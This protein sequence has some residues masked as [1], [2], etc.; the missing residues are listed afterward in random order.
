MKKSNLILFLITTLV[1]STYAQKDD[2]VV[3]MTVNGK[4]VSKAEFVRIY[5]KNNA[6]EQSFDQ[7]SLNEYLDLFINFKLKVA[8]AESLGLD[9]SKAFIDELAGYRKQLAKPYL[10]DKEVDHK[11]LLEAYDHLLW[12]VKASHILLK[13]DENASP[14][15]TLKVYNRIMDFRKKILD[16]ESFELVAKR[17]SE[18]PSA[19]S[20]GGSLGYFTGFQMVYPFERVAFSTPVGE[21]SMPVRTR[22]GYHLIKVFDKRPARGKVKVAHLMVAIPKTGGSEEASKA[23]AD[24]LLQL[25]KEGK[26]FAQ[27]AKENSD[28]HGSAAKGGELPMF[29]TGRMVPEF[30]AAAFKLESAGEISPLVK[31]SY[32][33]HIIK[34]LE[35]KGIEP[36]EDMKQE[37]K[38]RISKD[39]RSSQ[40][41]KALIAQL[42]REYNFSEDKVRVNNFYTHVTDSILKGN[43]NGESARGL[44]GKLFTL[45]GKDYTEADFTDYL[46][47]HK[48][49][50]TNES[51]QILVNRLYAQWVDQSIISYEESRLEQKYP[52]FKYLMTEYHD[53][54][55][56][57]ELSDQMVWTKAV[58]DTAGLEA[59][60]EKNKSNYMWGERLD[61]SIY[62]IKPDPKY[63]KLAPEDCTVGNAKTFPKIIKIAK[64]RKPAKL[65][66]DEMKEKLTALN[67]KNKSNLMVDVE[68]GLFAR[69]DN[70]LID[71]IDWKKGMVEKP[72]DGDGKNIIVV[73]KVIPPQV[74]TLKEARGLVTADYQNY[75][76]AEW[77]KE[78]RAKY[79]VVVNEEVLKTIK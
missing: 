30:E 31:T 51:V 9:T 63:N 32:G 53:G 18:D 1:L 11:L 56:L 8:E 64:K 35:K 41:R 44:N 52:D 6:N 21:V 65:S 7:K 77:I 10:V 59:F 27:L 76:E 26:D 75:L 20:N 68:D 13:V 49:K 71:D 38:S 47:S 23:K 15:D 37:L 39:A 48:M 42:K 3:L 22:F 2:E 73:R 67:Q 5:K 70:V 46:V 14:K 78:L 43:W 36:F 57:F 40:S 69:K 24:S 4:E 19:K 62:E 17:G 54:I 79:P 29:G 45:D 55:L 58:K 66:V 12:D 72:A 33:F 61:A 25:I 50:S 28:D 34:L 16:G 60:Y 74:K